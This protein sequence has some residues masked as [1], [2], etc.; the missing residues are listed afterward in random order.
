MLAS[1]YVYWDQ[2]PAAEEGPAAEIV[3]GEVPP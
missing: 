2:G 1:L 3:V